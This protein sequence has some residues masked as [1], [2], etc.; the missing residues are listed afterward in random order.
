M[1]PAVSSSA[2]LRRRTAPRSALALLLATVGLRSTWL[3]F[4]GSPGPSDAARTS[5]TSL[6]VNMFESFSNLVSK[7]IGGNGGENDEELN[8]RSSRTVDESRARVVEVDMPLG[9]EFEEKSGGDIYIKAVD[10]DSDAW[11]KGVRSGAQLV[12]VS[13]T[14]G[15]EM[16]TTR[17]VGM[18][19]FTTVVKSRFGSTIKLALEKEDQN[20]ISSFLAAWSKPKESE[21]KAQ[22]RQK[23]LESVFEEEERKLS[24]NGG[25][26]G[27]GWFR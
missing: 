6:R 15:D 3:A 1:A 24:G 21:E 25:D 8:T 19:Q 12:M 11:D 17:K 5:R 26:S 18:T 16:W 9:V 10:K 4:V 7:N 22:Q 27:G 23:K 2:S 20:V 14:F 13:A